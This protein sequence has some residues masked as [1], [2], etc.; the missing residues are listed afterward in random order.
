V[1]PLAAGLAVGVWLGE[2]VSRKIAQGLF[3]RIVHVSLAVRGVFLILRAA[4]G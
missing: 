3:R 2:K 1:S 4:L